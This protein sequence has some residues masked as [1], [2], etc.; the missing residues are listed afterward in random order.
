MFD[1]IISRFTDKTYIHKTGKHGIKLESSFYP[2]ERRTLED[3][4]RVILRSDDVI[5]T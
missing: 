1:P 3:F 2:T 4:H 5:T